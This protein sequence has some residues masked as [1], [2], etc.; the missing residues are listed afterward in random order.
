M[1]V[2]AAYLLVVL[3]GN[4]S[5]SADNLNSILGSVGIEVDEDKLNLLLSQVSSLRA[6]PWLKEAETERFWAWVRFL[7][8]RRS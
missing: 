4:A 2:I 6:K 5:P 3:G 7:W 1:K 8:S